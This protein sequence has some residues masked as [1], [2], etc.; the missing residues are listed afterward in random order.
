MLWY[1]VLAAAVGSVLRYLADFY[2]PRRGIL[3]VN[4]VGSCV[5]GIVFGLT[6]SQLLDERLVLVLLGGFTGSLTT[7]STVA[8]T[9]AQQAH[10]RPRQAVKTWLQHVGLSVLGCAF[11]I[12]VT[13]NITTMTTA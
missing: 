10:N 12:I 4:I 9:T 6:W 7:Y 13:L 5:A 8:V 11:G 1:F 2:L 3:L